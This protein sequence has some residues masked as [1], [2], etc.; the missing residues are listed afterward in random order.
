MPPL[1]PTLTRGTEP[2]LSSPT[3][4]LTAHFFFVSS[5]SCFQIS[6]WKDQAPATHLRAR[7]GNIPWLNASNLISILKDLFLAHPACFNCAAFYKTQARRSSSDLFLQCVV[8]LF[9]CAVWKSNKRRPTLQLC[10]QTRQPVLSRQMFVCNNRRTPR[11]KDDLKN[12]LKE[13]FRAFEVAL[14]GKVING[15]LPDVDGSLNNFSLVKLFF[16]NLSDWWAVNV[17]FI[18]SIRD[19]LVRQP[20]II[21]HLTRVS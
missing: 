3:W 7:L 12:S 18:Y 11:L 21:I 9:H 15:V 5:F 16:F 6:D 17:I 2:S 8:I 14:F 20:L 19:C 10:S 4:R 13:K 1:W